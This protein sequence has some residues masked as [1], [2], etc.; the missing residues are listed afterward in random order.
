MINTTHL[1]HDLDVG[2]EPGYP[3]GCM[4]LRDL[5]N[6]KPLGTSLQRL[7]AELIRL[8]RDVLVGI[9]VGDELKVLSSA[10]AITPLTEAL[11]A[12]S[13]ASLSEAGFYGPQHLEADETAGGNYL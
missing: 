3:C 8:A 9:D 5:A 7:A 11:I 10:A 6:K 1:P 12:A 4:T 13:N 2:I